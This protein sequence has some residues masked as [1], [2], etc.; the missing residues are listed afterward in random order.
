MP[1]DDSQKTCIL[2]N[3]DKVPSGKTVNGVFYCKACN[4]QWILEKRKSRRYSSF[5][6]N[7]ETSELITEFITIFDSNLQEEDIYVK[8][9]SILKSRLNIQRTNIV[10]LDNLSKIFRIRYTNYG[11]HSTE[12]KLKK[13]I[14]SA[15]DKEHI[16]N[17]CIDE[18][19]ICSYSISNF[20][21][22][23]FSLY[24]KIATVSNFQTL[25]PI[26]YKAIPLGLVSLDF[27]TKEEQDIAEENIKVISLIIGQFSIALYNAL[28]YTKSTK[29]YT[30]YVNLNSACLLLNKLYMNNSAEIMRMTLLSI[31]SFINTDINMLLV[32]HK[33][34][35]TITI[36]KL[37]RTIDDLNL[38]QQEIPSTD[39]NKY[40][41]LFNVRESTL[42]K[43]SK[44]KITRVLG[45]KGVEVLV[46]P[47]FI[48]EGNE[49]TFALAR[50]SKRLFSDDE[51]D[52]L[53][54][55]SSQVKITI[56]NSFLTQKIA[57][58]ERLAKEVEIAKEIQ[59]NL[60]PKSMPEHP[61]Y[62]FAGFMKP[63]R[64]IGGD[65]Y[66][67]IVSPDKSEYIFAIGDVSG[68]GIPAGMV[69]ATARTIIHSIVRID[70]TPWEIVEGVNTFLY[71]NYKD[72]SILRFMSLIIFKWKCNSN[73]FY[74]SGAGHGDVYVYRNQTKSI[75]MVPTNGVI[76]GIQQTIFEFQNE[77]CIELQEGDSILMFTDGVTEA[78]NPKSEP[79]EGEKLY[80]AYKKNAEEPSK[81]MLN[82][83][84]QD[85]QAFMGEADQH[86]DLTMVLI[87]RKR[88]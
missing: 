44:E 48:V 76:L 1:L 71:Y 88:L 35:K 41:K 17:Q 47:S 36:H 27:E 74:F 84:F 25:F 8:L 77:G 16:Y 40:A 62:E 81:S 2:C 18:K 65:Y 53:S 87:K 73:S 7:P 34:A 26:Y 54:N 49:Y 46:L 86:D 24:Q 60:L 5:F 80:L 68:K 39:Y 43:T 45:C 13:L 85:I 31:A 83:I 79:Y 14:Y 20:T 56:E 15:Q 28:T 51:I 75:E 6:E 33:K 52:L 59:L 70:S 30:D 21:T 55:Y 69:M 4:R 61:L 12:Y 9:S 19:K 23:Y 38:E 82:N 10:L 29:K 11:D 78:M 32:N 57:A 22:R 64:E 58:Q 50:N 42:F 66:D 3:E 67:I 37:T 63:A 72:S